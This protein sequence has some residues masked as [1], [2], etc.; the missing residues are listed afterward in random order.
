MNKRVD[1]ATGT[2]TAGHERDGIEEL[3]T[4]MPRWWLWTFYASIVFAIG[5]VIVYP[6]IPLLHNGTQG[7]FGWTSRG[8]LAHEMAEQRQRE[9]PMLAALARTPIEHLPENS[10]LMRSAVAGGRAAF[11]VDCVQCHGA[12]AA[13]SKGYPNLNDDDWLWGGDLKAIEYTVTHGARQPND[14]QPHVSQMPAFGRDGIL[15]AEQIDQVAGHVL[16]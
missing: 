10:A 4:P 15:T 1:Q 5:Y 9:A 6:A 8:Q 2:D 16:S 7:A 14:P 12:G 11:K 3:D 13:G